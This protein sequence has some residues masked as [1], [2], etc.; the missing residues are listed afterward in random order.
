[1]LGVGAGWSNSEFLAF[2]EWEE[3]VKT[4]ISKAKEALRLILE[5]WNRQEPF[6]F[7]GKFYKAKS[8]ILEPK[9]IQIPHVPLWFGTQG[10]SMLELASK[11]AEGWLPPVPGVA[12]EEYERIVTF[13][14]NEEKVNLGRKTP[15]VV[16]CNGTLPEL[17]SNRL[18]QFKQLGCEVALLVRSTTSTLNED[19]A[20]F[21]KDVARS[22]S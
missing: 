3:D 8:A 18:E 22:Y 10:H 15:V 17:R 1:M 2:S 11:Y 16:A 14:R 13:F 12:I 21:S 4:R 6:D 20:S 19:I 5:L 9:S 7:E